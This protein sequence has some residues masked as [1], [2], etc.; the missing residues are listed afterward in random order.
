MS[1]CSAVA[2]V[3]VLSGCAG[4][5][6]D[7]ALTSGVGVEACSEHVEMAHRDLSGTVAFEPGATV[8]LRD[9]SQP[10]KG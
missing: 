6:T 1:R 9:G 8:Y 3:F 5:Q 4:L 7:P 10:C 2:L